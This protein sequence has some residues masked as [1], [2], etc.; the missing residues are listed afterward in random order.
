VENAEIG[1][2]NVHWKNDELGC[3]M[4]INPDLRKIEMNYNTDMFMVSTTIDSKDICNVPVVNKDIPNAEEWYKIRNATSD[5]Y[6]NPAV[7][8]YSLTHSVHM[9]TLP[10]DLLKINNDWIQ[11]SKDLIAKSVVS[12]G[13]YSVDQAITDL[14]S[15]KQKIG[16]NQTLDW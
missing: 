3:P 13:S 4:V 6:E 14:K 11:Q 10:A 7:S 5:L 16:Q 12:G 15:L 2:E 9:P 1:M 8:L